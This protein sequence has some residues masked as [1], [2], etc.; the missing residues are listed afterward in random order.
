MDDHFYRFAVFG[1]FALEEPEIEVEG[2]GGLD[3]GVEGVIGAVVPLV[4]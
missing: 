1:G 3:D 4:E 2:H